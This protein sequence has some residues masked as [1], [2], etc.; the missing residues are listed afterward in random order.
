V[1][2]FFH[3]G[4]LLQ[5]IDDLQDLEEDLSRHQWTLAGAQAQAGCLNGYTD[6][7]LALIPVI[8]GSSRLEG[9]PLRQLIDRSCRLLILEAAATHTDVYSTEYLS[10]LERHSPVRFVYLRSIRA[11][12]R[13]TCDT[14]R[15][16]A[17]RALPLVG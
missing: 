15:R 14:H 5:L 17:S 12:M 8:L 13:D 6:R 2:F 9:T 11:R 3:F 10:R 1:E 7:L 16:E 4:V